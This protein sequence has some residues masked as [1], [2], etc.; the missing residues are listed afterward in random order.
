VRA[1]SMACSPASALI[2]ASADEPSTVHARRKNALVETVRGRVH[3]R[4]LTILQRAER[5]RE[6]SIPARAPAVRSRRR[7]AVPKLCAETSHVP[8]PNP[9]ITGRSS[10]SAPTEAGPIRDGADVTDPTQTR[11][12]IEQRWP[13]LFEGLTETQ[14]WSVVQSLALAWHEGWEPNR[15][16][17]ANLTEFAAGRIDHAEYTRRSDAVSGCMRGSA[18]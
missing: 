18:R 1:M 6:R 17:V 13:E 15:A 8:K 5:T 2:A 16:D 14:R 7:H 11:F 9:S 10:T 4:S 12:D 3:I